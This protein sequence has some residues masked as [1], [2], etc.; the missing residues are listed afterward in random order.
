L[1]RA[2]HQ[3]QVG[4]GASLPGG[5]T[6]PPLFKAL[7]DVTGDA[8]EVGSK[9]T[10]AAGIGSVQHAVGT[11]AGEE[12]VLDGVLDF[13]LARGVAPGGGE[14]GPGARPGGARDPPPPSGA[15]AGRPPYPPPASCR[16]L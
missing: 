3:L 6:G 2:R 9:A 13:L 16:G 4:L 5:L 15:A 11:E 8:E 10:G 1:L 7:G 14:G 12:D